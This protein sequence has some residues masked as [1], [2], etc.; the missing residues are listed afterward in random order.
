MKIVFA[1]SEMTPLCKTGGLA[2]VVGA[3]PPVLASK[4]H[5]IHV[6]LPGYGS[7]DREAWGF[8]A[9]SDRQGIYLGQTVTALTMS[10]AEYRGVQVHLL[11]NAD[12][13]SR[14]GLYGDENGDYGDNDMRFIFYSRA[15]V[16]AM[17]KLGI[18]PDI[19]HGH[20]WQ[21]GLVMTYLATLY[22]QD[23]F[24]ADTR[25]LF[26][27]HNLGYQGIFSFGAFT[28]TGLSVSEFH[29]QKMEYYGNVSLLKG[30][31]VYADALST[32]S[33]TYAREVATPAGGLGL[34]GVFYERK[35]SLHGIVNGIDTDMWDPSGDPKIPAAYSYDDLGGKKTCRAALLEKAG[36]NAKA[37]DMVIG[38][39]SRLDDQK[40]FD[41]IESAI[42]QIVSLGVRLIVLGTGT[43]RHHEA[44]TA[45]QERYPD[46]ISVFLR[47]D[48][49]LA[50]LIYA[51]SDA[52]LMPS[53]YEP[54]GLGQLIAMRYGTLPIVRST[55]G[56]ADTVVDLT[57][58]PRTGNGFAF[59]DY[60]PGTL[61]DAVERAV[62]SFGKKGRSRWTNAMRRAMLGDY[63]WTAAAAK[64]IDLYESIRNHR[65]DGLPENR[66]RR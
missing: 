27:V 30:G 3:L 52:F 24:F 48:E 37:G 29:W 26:T 59:T 2:D 35:D 22:R 40:G 8:N 19:V 15:T 56:L 5:E 16:E 39:V 49:G 43:L 18:R 60:S 23:P 21:A 44:M 7:I 53:R 4:G 41:I 34:D 50:H 54:C 10:S 38:I 36:L 32:V 28:L 51:G 57:Q 6:M 66:D 47:F 20:D 12:F 63:S 46:S 31:L 55:G 42:D 64:Y 11:E 13:F 45:L 14:Q 25:T 58:D 65:K 17:K 61:A 62:D 9:R 33:R 1:A